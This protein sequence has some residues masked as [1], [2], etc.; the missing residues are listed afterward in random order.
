MLYPLGSYTC[1]YEEVPVQIQDCFLRVYPQNPQPL[2]WPTTPM[3]RAQLATSESPLLPTPMVP[4]AVVV[5]L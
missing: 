4:V 3:V 1:Y 2:R 5:L